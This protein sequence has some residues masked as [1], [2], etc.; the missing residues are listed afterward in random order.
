LH[1]NFVFEAPKI[2]NFSSKSQKFVSLGNEV[3]M[4]IS[5]NDMR[6]QI[7]NNGSLTHESVVTNHDEV[8]S[9]SHDDNE[10]EI[11]CN[12]I[13]PKKVVQDDVAVDITP[14]KVSEVRDKADLRDKNLSKN[15]VD[16]STSPAKYRLAYDEELLKELSDDEV[17]TNSIHFRRVCHDSDEHANP[18]IDSD[19]ST[20][21]SVK[22]ELELN[23]PGSVTYVV[24]SGWPNENA[25]ATLDILSYVEYNRESKKSCK[26]HEFAVA[27]G[28][29]SVHQDSYIHVEGLSAECSYEI[30]L[31]PHE[32]FTAPSIDEA[33]QP[34]HCLTYHTPPATT[35][36]FVQEPSILSFDRESQKVTF[37]YV[38]DLPAQLYAITVVHPYVDCESANQHKLMDI[39]TK[40]LHTDTNSGHVVDY[41]GFGADEIRTGS[42]STSFGYCGTFT[43]AIPDVENIANVYKKLC[44]ESKTAS[45]LY[46]AVMAASLSPNLP[47]PSEVVTIPLPDEIFA[48]AF[49]EKIG[50]QESDIVSAKY[51]QLP[52]TLLN[53]YLTTEFESRFRKVLEQGRQRQLSLE[54]NVLRQGLLSKADASTEIRLVRQHLGKQLGDQ[55]V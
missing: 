27:C 34:A 16:A 17:A 38:L 35:P 22:I 24:T 23:H 33:S 46:V 40:K 8:S 48:D 49:E 1:Q 9:K 28:T 50:V 15:K 14:E 26:I 13:T 31:V 52:N 18:Y 39:I 5:Y 53:C 51:N 36:K 41:V 29:K 44:N 11:V 19:A 47:L 42:G 32:P 43:L 4:P 2:A 7:L 37:R 21:H 20:S 3:K 54:N 12:N 6:E 10:K 45:T 55:Y 30:F 25:P